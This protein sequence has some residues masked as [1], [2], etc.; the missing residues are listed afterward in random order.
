[1][2]GDVFN[3]D[4]W[5]RGPMTLEY[6]HHKIGVLKRHCQKVGRDPAEI[7]RT[8]LMPVMVT[9]DEATAANF[10]ASRNLGPGTVAGPKNYVTERIGEFI[11]AGVDEIMFGGLVTAEIEQ[12]LRFEAD[13]LAAFD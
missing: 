3:L 9:D 12:Y 10:I 5:A 6:Y 13:I 2:Y 4:G 1:M 11:D 8:I 7:K